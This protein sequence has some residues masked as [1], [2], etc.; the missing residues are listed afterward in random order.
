MP[1]RCAPTKLRTAPVATARRTLLAAGTTLPLLALSGT[2]AGA[3]DWPNRPIRLV[4]AFPPGGLADVMSRAI[5]PYLTEQ[6]KQP[7]VIDNRAGAAGNVAGV[8]VV[9]GG[10]DGH[11]F[12]VTVSTTESVNPT[13]FP[14]M[15]FEPR[16]DLQ[17]VGLLANSQLFLI[18]RPDLPVD[19]AAAFL[20]YARAH[21]GQLSYGS[22]GNGTTPHLAGELLKQNGRISATHVPYRGAAPA[23]QDVMAGQVDFAFAPGTVF[24]FGRAGKLK[25][26]AVAS[27][28]RTRNAPDIPT[29]T[30]IGVDR[31][32]ADTLF[33]VYAPA[34]MPAAPV[35]AL[36]GALRFSLEQPDIGRRFAEIGAEATPMTAA[37]YRAL[38]DDE[39]KVFPDIVRSSG[40]R[41]E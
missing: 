12:L 4:V 26:L 40:I 24:A 13:M 20:E 10:G 23:I 2:R 8:E 18:V 7:V 25:V 28:N 30:E 29:F 41:A 34:G 17:P 9:R 1:A 5:A 19:S 21:P 31:V 27:R 11:S 6:L 15:P 14:R 36:N 16:K 32:F 39:L 3:A 37:G 33:G 35:D 22:A 38:V